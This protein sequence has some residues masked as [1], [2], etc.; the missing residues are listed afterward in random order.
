M[1]LTERQQAISVNPTDL[2][3]IVKTGDTSQ[4]VAGSSYKANISQIFELTAGCCLTAATYFHGVMSFINASG[5][6]S[7]TVDGLSFTGGSGNCINDLYV[8]NIYPCPTNINIQPQSTGK[9]FF[10]ALSGA[11]GFT[12]DLVSQTSP[13]AARLG[14]NTNTPQYTF[15]MYSWDHRSRFLYD[16]K[17]SNLHRI[18]LTGGSDMVL[19]VGPFSNTSNGLILTI[20]GNNEKIGR[21]HV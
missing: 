6:T 12:V 15:D 21:A 8:N 1:F 5:G 2:I 19:G 11:S 20:R 10:G 3:H 17:T 4:N 18:V 13:N 7:F 16:D 9:V 14:L